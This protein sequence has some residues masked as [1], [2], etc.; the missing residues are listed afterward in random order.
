MKCDSIR[1]KYSKYGVKEYYEKFGNEYSNPHD[2]NVMQLLGQIESRRYKTGIDFSC[3]DGL[4]SICLDSIRWIGVDPFLAKRYSAVTGNPVIECSMEQVSTGTT[5]LPV[6][7][8][9]VCSYCFDIFE[10]S[11]IDLFLWRLSLICDTLVVIRANKKV[12]ESNWWHIDST[13]KR[14]RSVMCI[15]NRHVP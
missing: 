2:T 11:Y 14:G 8:L 4:V 7:D 15:Y 6:V 12:L 9:V 5:Q 13:F 3:G 10:R 1:E